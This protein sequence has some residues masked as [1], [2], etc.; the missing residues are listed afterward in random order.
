LP[1]T[2]RVVYVAQVVRTGER[3]LADA[4]PDHASPALELIR[5]DLEACL[6]LRASC[7]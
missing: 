5:H 6:A 1:G 4:A 3:M 2:I 7:R